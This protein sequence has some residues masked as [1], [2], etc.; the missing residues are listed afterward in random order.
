MNPLDLSGPEF[1]GFYVVTAAMAIVAA[2]VLRWI[3]RQPGGVPEMLPPLSSCEI[4]YLCGGKQL[5]VHAAFT[6]LV[7][8]NAC[9]STRPETITLKERL[10]GDAPP[11]EKAIYREVVELGSPS[12]GQV[13]SECDVIQ[14]RLEELGLPR[15]NKRWCP[16]WPGPDDATALAAVKLYRYRP[17]QADWLPIG[18]LISLA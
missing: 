10:P 5:A 1:L 8:D 11:L 14:T 15:G 17:R 9:H 6:R 3:L 7:H 13:N 2:G 18:L 12:H 4:A 16:L